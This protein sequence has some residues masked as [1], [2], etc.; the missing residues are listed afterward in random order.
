MRRRG[1][2]EGSVYQRKDGRWV[3]AVTIGGG[4]GTQKK[5]L[6]YGKTRQEAATN[7]ADLLKAVKDDAPLAPA[8]LTVAGF[9]QE[10]LSGVK[11]SLA[12]TTFEFYESILRVHVAPNLGSIR[13]SKLTP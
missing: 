3:G 7:L 4:R 9:A 11:G 6:A 5:K 10:W 12:P 1:N 8:R 2:N 13:L